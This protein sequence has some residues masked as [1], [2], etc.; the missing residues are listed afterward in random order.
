MD[1]ITL[2]ILIFILLF[3]LLAIGL[4]IGFAMAATGFL[5]S[6]ILID[7]NAALALLGQTAFETTITFNLSVVPM[8]ILM[9]YFAK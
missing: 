3:F 9:G 1:P 7:V 4:P 5:G 8:F 6:A 2:S